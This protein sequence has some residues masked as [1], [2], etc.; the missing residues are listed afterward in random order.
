MSNGRWRIA[1]QIAGAA[2]LLAL[3]LGAGALSSPA[4]AAPPAH[5]GLAGIGTTHSVTGGNL[6]V[7]IPSLPPNFRKGCDVASTAP[8]VEPWA[9]CPASLHGRT[10]PG[11]FGTAVVCGRLAGWQWTPRGEHGHA[12]AQAVSDRVGPSGTRRTR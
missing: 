1:P 6:M 4:G 10:E 7:S 5:A 2:F 11:W 9:P 8:C 3:A 12:R